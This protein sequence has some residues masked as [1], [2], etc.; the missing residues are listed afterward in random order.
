MSIIAKNHRTRPGARRP[1]HACKS[2][3][4]G[5]AVPAASVTDA[6]NTL[7]AYYMLST[8]G[9]AALGPSQCD[10]R[11]GR[12]RDGEERNEA[13]PRVAIACADE[14]FFVKS[15]MPIEWQRQ[16]RW[17]G[18]GTCMGS[19][20]TTTAGFRINLSWGVLCIH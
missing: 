17:Q 14:G 10:C 12:K 8:R 9:A 5:G 20:E 13:A 7:L 3:R 15:F 18:V 11:V 2:A 16:L 19:S 6:H 1:I 4:A